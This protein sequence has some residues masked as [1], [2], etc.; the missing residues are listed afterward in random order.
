MS[1]RFQKDLRLAK[2]RNLDL[3]LL[4]DVVEKLADGEKLDP[5]YC[6]HPLL[7]EYNNFRECHIKPDWLLIYHIDNDEL[8]L[9]LLRT[10]SHSDLF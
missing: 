5:S 6:D 1:N 7:G 4:Q 3:T 2:K 9:F 8:E 10:G